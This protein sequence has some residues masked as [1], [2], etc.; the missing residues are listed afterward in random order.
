MLINLIPI[1]P[2][3]GGRILVSLLPGKAAWQLS[4]VEPYGF[5]ILIALLYSDVLS[6]PLQQA[7]DGVTQFILLITGQ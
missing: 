5:V 7:M 4:R 2:L 3:D 6:K 1:P